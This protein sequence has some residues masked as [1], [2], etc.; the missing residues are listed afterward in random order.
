MYYKIFKDVVGDWRWHYKASNGRTIAH[1]GEGYRN[2]SDC[3]NGIS[4][5]KGSSTDPVIE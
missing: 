5:M 2:K 3:L 1:S 4:I